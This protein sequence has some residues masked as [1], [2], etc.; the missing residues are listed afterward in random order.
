MLVKIINITILFLMMVAIVHSYLLSLQSKT[1]SPTNNKKRIR[2]ELP[3]LLTTEEPTI[4]TFTTDTASSKDLSNLL[5]DNIYM[6]FSEEDLDKPIGKET[7]SSVNASADFSEQKKTSDLHDYFKKEVFPKIK[8]SKD[9]TAFDFY[10]SNNTLPDIDKMPKC[11]SNDQDTTF[12]LNSELPDSSTCSNMYW[13]YQTNSETEKS[14]NGGEIIDG[15]HGWESQ[16]D[17][18]TV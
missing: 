2:F 11:N 15:L 14:I 17:F 5:E 18:C 4:E 7:S 16:S 6:S 10:K 1:Y 8:T 9:P 12:K 3:S 13:E